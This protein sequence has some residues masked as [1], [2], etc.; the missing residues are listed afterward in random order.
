MI[1]DTQSLSVLL[2]NI[3][4]KTRRN[5]SPVSIKFTLSSDAEGGAFF[6]RDGLMCSFTMRTLDAV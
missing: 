3:G 5:E 2:D 6:S 4:I 1:S